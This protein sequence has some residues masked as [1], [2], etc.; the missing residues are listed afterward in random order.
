M[1]ALK[2]FVEHEG[3]GEYCGNFLNNLLSFYLCKRTNT[4]QKHTFLVVFIAR[5]KWFISGVNN[6]LHS[7]MILH[8]SSGHVICF[9]PGYGKKR[10][11]AHRFQ[12]V[13]LSGQ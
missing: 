2:E 11:N 6:D 3:K 10:Q 8:L 7:F 9:C 5:S 4:V 12:R 13:Y 1:R